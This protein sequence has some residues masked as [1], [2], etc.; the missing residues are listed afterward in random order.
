M[1]LNMLCVHFTVRWMR[2][3]KT[4]GQVMLL[5][6]HLSRIWDVRSDNSE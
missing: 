3:G 1:G 4:K 2:Q 6:G 5:P